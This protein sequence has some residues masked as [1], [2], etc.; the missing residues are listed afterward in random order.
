MK[1]KV[2]QSSGEENSCEETSSEEKSN[3]ERSSE[4]QSSEEKSSEENSSDSESDEPSPKKPSSSGISRLKNAVKKLI[5]GI[6]IKQSK[7]VKERQK[8]P[9]HIQVRIIVSILIFKILLQLP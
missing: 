1:Q 8:S 2:K 4:E 7:N 9:I 3:E 5:P 6:K